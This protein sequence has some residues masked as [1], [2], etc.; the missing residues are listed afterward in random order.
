MGCAN[1]RKD[2]TAEQ[3]RIMAE[4]M[5]I[6]IKSDSHDQKVNSAAFRRAG[7]V[8]LSIVAMKRKEEV[9]KSDGA[10]PERMMSRPQPSGSPL[11]V[12]AES[13]PLLDGEET[14]TNPLLPG[15][16]TSTNP[17]LAGEETPVA[18]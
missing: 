17:L 5:M 8:T 13:N 11:D 7:Q 12:S 10:T 18:V 2:E 3:E 16:E 15:E 4:D 14:S 6:R 9:V 1:S